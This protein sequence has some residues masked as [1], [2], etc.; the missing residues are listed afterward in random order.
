M[1]TQDAPIEDGHD[2]ATD[3]QRL[4]GIIQQVRGDVALGNADDTREMVRQR[5]EEAGMSAS[6]SD[7]DAVLSAV[8][9]GTPAG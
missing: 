1:D 6:E 4:E 9:G 2:E 3:D 8:D 7:I 5:L